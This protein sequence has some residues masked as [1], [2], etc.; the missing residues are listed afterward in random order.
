MDLIV[1]II[2]HNPRQDVILQSS[3]EMFASVPRNKSF[4]HAPEGKGLPIG[5]LTS[6]LFANVYMNELDHFVKHR[7]KAKYYGRYVDDMVLFHEDADVLN[8]WYEEIE[9]FL[10]EQ[11]A[12]RL[13]PHKKW[14]NRA[15]K[16][17]DFVG[18]IIKPGRTY[19]RQ[20]SLVR[21]K[22]K[23]RTWGLDGGMVDAHTLDCLSA[24]VNSYL[25]MLR[26]VDGYK[27]RKS[28]CHRVKNLFI[29]AD[30]DYTKILP[31][32]QEK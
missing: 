5:N 13:H 15:D 27:A 19:L 25:G 17:V 8:G 22:Q 10:H 29:H 4:M 23:I 31:A 6:Q 21:C 2:K 20:T 12:M 14:L 26:Q 28:I 16:G 32:K 9:A 18:F 24:S 1:Q 3:P 7:L 11:L 30:K